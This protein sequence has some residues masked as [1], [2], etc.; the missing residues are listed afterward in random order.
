MAADST[1]VQ[2]AYRAH[3]YYGKPVDDAR[4]KLFK[5][6]REVGENLDTKKEREELA[7][8]EAAQAQQKLEKKQQDALDK[9]A[10]KQ[11]EL[12]E[13]NWNKNASKLIAA[14]GSMSSPD[15][16]MATDAVANYLKPM[17]L[18]GDSTEQNMAMNDLSLAA[19][20]INGI[21]EYRLDNASFFA[22]ANKPGETFSEDGYSLALQDDE[23][24]LDILGGHTG[25]SALSINPS[26]NEEGSATGVEFGIIGGYDEE[27]NPVHMSLDEADGISEK[28]KVDVASKANI[29]SLQNEMASKAEEGT[30]EDNFDSKGVRDRVTEIVRNGKQLSLMYDPLIKSTSFKDDLY[31]SGMLNGVTYESL[32]ISPEIAFEMDK[33]QDGLAN[34]TLTPQDQNAI[35]KMFIQSPN[36]QKERDEMLVEY[37]TQAVKQAWQTKHQEHVDIYRRN[38]PVTPLSEQQLREIVDQGKKRDLENM[39]ITPNQEFAQ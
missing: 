23:S 29:L 38:N 31:S 35:V 14:D 18:N 5:N 16:G 13:K 17:Y 21:K 11:R 32:G 3:K 27:G 1:L 9:E 30:H 39:E 24:A 33:N 4:D 2:G 22:N 34:D 8:Q 26:M 36:L 6:L 7:A 20:Q 12:K 15:Y 19:K 10:A 28:F 37:Y 25:D